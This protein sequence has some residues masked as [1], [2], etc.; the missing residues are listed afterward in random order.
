MK[1][2][3]S[4][5]ITFKIVLLTCCLAAGFTP[6]SGQFTYNSPYTR[7]GIGDLYQLSGGLNGGMGGLKY[8]FNSPFFVNPSNPA[9]YTA[10]KK[11]YFTFDAGLSGSAARLSKDTSARDE[12][13]LNLNNISFGVPLGKKWGGAFGLLPFSSVGYTITDPGYSEDF[14]GYSTT[15]Q[16]TGG[17]NR[18]FFGVARE[19]IPDLSIGVNANYMFGSLNYLRTLVFDSTNY[20]NLRSRNSRIIHDFS[21]DAGLQ[22]NML[23]NESQGT[24]LMLGLSAG[25]PAK[26]SGREDVLTE[27]FRYS[28]AGVVVVRD[29]IEN[30]TGENG[31]IQMPLSFG[32]G[33]SFNRTGRW[34]IGADFAWQDWSGFSSFGMKDSLKSSLQ[35]A[36]GGE[37]KLNSVLLRAGLRYHQSY[38]EIRENRLNEM[39]ISFGVGWPVYNK[40]YSISM[41]SAGI[42]AGRRG[43]KENHLIREDFG[44]IWL[45]FTMSQERWFKRREYN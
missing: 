22:Y 1:Y 32:G 9:S 24:H 14:G 5:K 29:T 15:Y 33:F 20:L 2:L 25:I 35:V 4:M 13:Q 27:T 16:G 19:I 18:V 30:A 21:F 8:C 10:F 42:E 40:N 43:T 28:T 3:I 39:G 38:L 17:L 31:Y 36:L 26:L 7:Y 12:Q 34:L 23:L 45:S 11:N 41:I 6:V 37:Y 44:R